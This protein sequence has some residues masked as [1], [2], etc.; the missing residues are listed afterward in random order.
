MRWYS[1]GVEAHSR[2]PLQLKVRPP[3]R[4]KSRQAPFRVEG[5]SGYS[6]KGERAHG[7]SRPDSGK[8]L[9]GMTVKRA[10]TA[11]RAPTSTATSKSMNFFRQS[12]H[13][14]LK[15]LAAQ[16]DAYVSPVFTQAKSLESLQG[17]ALNI[18]T[19][20]MRPVPPTARLAQVYIESRA[21]VK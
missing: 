9:R 10:Q 21:Q 17:T 4:P 6:E 16:N 12:T 13:E 3:L 5:E 19:M 14:K 11:R 8:V 2:V 15:Q 20:R 1:G 18:R 7:G